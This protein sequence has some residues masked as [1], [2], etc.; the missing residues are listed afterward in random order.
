M[1]KKTIGSF[2]AALRKANGMTQQELADRLGVSNKAVSRWERDENAPDLSLIPA[3]AEIFGVTCDELLKGERIFYDAEEPTKPEPKVDKQ[4][5]ALVNR[6]IS[7]FRFLI[8]LSLALSAV[9]FICMLGISYGFYRP[10]IGFAVMMLFLVGAVT[11]AFVG[12]T[13]MKTIKQENEL[14]ENADPTLLDKFNNTLKIDSFRSFFIAFSAFFLTLPLTI[15]G[16]EHPYGVL[17]MED[18]LIILCILIPIL[19]LC[20]W[21]VKD[22]Y[23]AWVTEQPY[24]TDGYA[25]N[26]FRRKLNLLQLGS[27]LLAGVIYLA[28]PL[29]GK[30]IYLSHPQFE[31][32][33][34][35]SRWIFPSLPLAFLVCNVVLFIIFCLCYKQHR[36]SFLIIGLRNVTLSIPTFCISYWLV[37]CYEWSNGVLQGY[38][39]DWNLNN[40]FI[41]LSLYLI[42][43]TVFTALDVGKRGR[44]A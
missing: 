44:K 39:L 22:R 31:F 2:I 3:I 20:R 38:H 35:W 40:I 21:A 23:F 1:E 30:V 14:F 36:S 7:S 29:L 13:S 15:A 25:E 4:L 37:G 18:N 26:P 19:L 34:I 6:S 9:G 11:V 28:I 27:I 17:V 41:T 24:H 43:V 12:I 10:I 8:Y 16:I 33:E 42:I 32:S 5:K